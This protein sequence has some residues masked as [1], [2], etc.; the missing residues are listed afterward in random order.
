MKNS[1][2]IGVANPWQMRTILRAPE[3]DPA[4][5]ADPPAAPPAGDPAPP[6]ADPPPAAPPAGEPPAPPQDVQPPADPPGP[7]DAYELTAP[8][9]SPFDASDLDRFSAIAREEGWT[10][11][12]AQQV[13]A[14]D[15]QRLQAR[16]E[17]F[18]AETVADPVLG[19]ANLEQTQ[20]LVS[21]ALDHHV[22]DSTPDGAALRAY[23]QKSGFL[24]NRLIVGLFAKLGKDL[25]EDQPMRATEPAAPPPKSATERLGASLI[26]SGVKP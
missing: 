7:P 24:H 22:P 12:Q 14:R 13:L 5:P 10:N 1:S 8:E 16:V 19:G 25:V 17:A 20:Q 4:P 23:L 21:R 18:K 15:A 11:E 3:G 9:G 26:P 2:F 6:P